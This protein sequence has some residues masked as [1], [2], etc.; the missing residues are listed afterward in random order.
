D[1]WFW[2]AGHERQSPEPEDLNPRTVVDFFPFAE[3][4][5]NTAEYRRPGTRT[6]AQAKITFPAQHLGNLNAPERGSSAGSALEV[7][8]PGTVTFRPPTNQAVWAYGNWSNGTWH[9]VMTRPMRATEGISL[10]P[11]E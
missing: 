10:Q 4:I 1:V 7:G 2:N 8:G 6:Q 9:V 11:G 5:A 3:T